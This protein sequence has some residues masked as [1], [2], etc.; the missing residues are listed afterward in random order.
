VKLQRFSLDA[1]SLG[2]V[3]KL[4]R[5]LPSERREGDTLFI[6]P[7]G[8]LAPLRDEHPEFAQLIPVVTGEAMSHAVHGRMRP[9]MEQ[10]GAEP[11]H[12]LIRIPAPHDVCRVAGECV[13]YDSKRC[14]PRSKK[15][16]ECWSPEAEE[17]ALRAMGIVTLA[18]AENR[19]V[20]VVEGAEFVMSG[21][22]V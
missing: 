15:L 13:M 1:G 11:R 5:P 8:D 20:V 22:G 18:W 12:Q 4:L 2:G 16:P 14:Q 21:V 6:D 7:W 3:I 19:Y 17:D 9:L 10:I